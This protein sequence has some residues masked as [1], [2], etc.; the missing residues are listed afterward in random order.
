MRAEAVDARLHQWA[1]WVSTRG[2]SAGYPA[3]NTLHQNWQPGRGMGRLPASSGGAMH[4]RE[5]MT[6]EAIASLTVKLSDAVVVH[7]VKRGSVEQQAEQL[8]CAVSTV[9]ARVRE[10]K[11]QVAEWLTP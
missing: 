3:I 11:R 8:G 7:Y 4:V 6:H 5:R 10:A 9:H 1:Q 2:A